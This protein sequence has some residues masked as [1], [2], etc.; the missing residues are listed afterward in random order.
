MASAGFARTIRP[1]FNTFDGDIVFA[2]SSAS[3]AQT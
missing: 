2:L 3:A 1:V